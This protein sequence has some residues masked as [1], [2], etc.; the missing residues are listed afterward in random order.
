MNY[1]QSFYSEVKVVLPLHQKLRLVCRSNSGN[2][3]PRL[4]INFL[5]LRVGVNTGCYKIDNTLRHYKSD[6][7]MKP[8]DIDRA[9]QTMRYNHKTLLHNR[10]QSLIL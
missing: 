8:S 3:F 5:D 2:E 7:I 1:K 4:H 9:I 10:K 6:A